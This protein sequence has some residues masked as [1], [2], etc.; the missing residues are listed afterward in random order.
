MSDEIGRE[1]WA[2]HEAVS[3]FPPTRPMLG[4]LVFLLRNVFAG[5]IVGGFTGFVF[6]LPF[7]YLFG[8]PIVLVM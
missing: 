5:K 8:L 3:D 6:G 4:F 1:R 7:A 2:R